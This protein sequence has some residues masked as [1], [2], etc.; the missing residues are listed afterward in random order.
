MAQ[1]DE[2]GHQYG[3][4]KRSFDEITSESSLDWMEDD[5]SCGIYS[6]TCSYSSQ[7]ECLLMDWNA[8]R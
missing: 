7:D 5:N 3:R 8:K 1:C 4:S 6:N 2:I